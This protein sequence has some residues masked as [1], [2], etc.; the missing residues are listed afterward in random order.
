MQLKVEFDQSRPIYLQIIEDI[1]RQIATGV[2]KPGDKL[3]SQRDLAVQLQVNANTVQR[4][5]REMELLGIVETLRGQ[6]TFVRAERSIVEET[7]G[8]MVST[9]VEEFVTAMQALGY[10]AEAILL[11][12]RQTLADTAGNGGERNGK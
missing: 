2:V 8:D 6:G 4:A 1:K 10:D 12:V 5:Y 7:R 11:H 3:P 9:L